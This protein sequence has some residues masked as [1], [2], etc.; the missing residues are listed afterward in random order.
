VSRVVTPLSP[1][2][3]TVLPVEDPLLGL[4]LRTSKRARPRIIVEHG[5]STVPTNKEIMAALHAS[6][7]KG[8]MPSVL[9]ALT[10]IW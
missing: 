3:S 5:G 8:D 1:A 10:T 9:A 2:P 7:A 4:L 6:F